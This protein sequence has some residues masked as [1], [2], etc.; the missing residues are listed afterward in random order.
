VPQFILD[1]AIAKGQTCNIII[2][3]PRKIAAITVARRVASERQCNLGQL[4]GYQVGLD[5]MLQEDYKG[6]R[7]IFCTTGVIL[8]KMIQEKSMANYSHIILDEIHEREIDMDL[9]ITVVREFLLHNSGAT[10]LLLMSATLDPKMFIDYFTFDFDVITIKPAVIKLKA[11]RHFKIEKLYLDDLQQQQ[12]FGFN[13]DVVNYGKPGISENLYQLAKEIIVE[14]LKISR[15]SILVFLPGISQIELLHKVLKEEITSCL[16]CVLHSSLSTNDQQA[17]FMPTSKPKI[18]LATNIA[19]SSVT[20]NNISCVIDF[21]LTKII[22]ANKGSTMSSLQLDWAAKDSL[23]QRSGR[24]GRTCD[25]VVYRLIRRSFYSDR[26]QKFSTPEMQR[27]PLETVVLRIK[28]LDIES[29]VTLL[30]KSLSPPQPSAIAKSVLVLKEIGGLERVTD[31]GSFIHSDGKL[32]YVGRIMSALPLDVRVTKLVILGYVYSVLDEAIIIAAGLTIKSI[33]RN[34]FCDK[35]DDYTHKLAWADSS[36]CDFIAILNAYKLWKF[37]SEQG[38]LSDGKTERIWCNQHNLELKNL[39]EMRQ[40]IREI[41]ERL[42]DLKIESLYGELAV[43]WEEKEK[44]L[45]LKICLVGAFIPNFFIA[46]ESN[47]LQEQEIHKELCGKSPYNTVIFRKMD[48]KYIGEV[49]EE[50]IKQKL[51][52][53]GICRNRDN[54][55]IHFEKGSS[56]FMVEFVSGEAMIEGDFGERFDASLSSLVPGKTAPEVYK[57]VKLRKLGFRFKLDVMSSHETEA[58]AVKYGLVVDNNGFLERKKNVMKHPELCVLPLTCAQNLEGRVSHIDHC[59]KFYIQ[60]AT[61]TNHEIL[62][63]IQ[64]MLMQQVAQPFQNINELSQ[65]KLVAVLHSDSLKRGKV[66]SKK[67]SRDVECFLFDFGSTVKVSIDQIFAVSESCFEISERCF[68][69]KLSEIE[70]SFLKCPH[71][72]WT[73]QAVE[74]FRS[75]ALNRDAKVEVY[76]VVGTTASVKLWIED[77][78][79]NEELIEAEFAQE[80]DENFPSKHNHQMRMKIQALSRMWYGP[81]KEWYGHP[82]RMI[83]THVPPPPKSKCNTKL[84]LSGPHSPMETSLIHVLLNSRPFDITVD[85]FSVNSVVLFDN[86]ANIHGRLLVAANVTT[87][88]GRISLHETTMLPEIP[89]LPMLL[90]MIFAPD[91][92]FRRNEERTKYECMQFGL[93]AYTDDSSSLFPEHDCVLPVNFHIDQKDF[94]DV[95]Y[96]RFLM[97]HLLT[98]EPNDQISSLKDEEKS[99]LLRRVKSQIIK[100]LSKNREP[101]VLSY[102]SHDFKNWKTE[103]QS[104]A[105]RWQ[106]VFVG[107]GIYHHIAHPPLVKESLNIQQ[108]VGE[109][110]TIKSEMRT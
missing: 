54:I 62:E 106:D 92:I 1:D 16:I 41:K 42:T 67:S 29:P 68:E 105:R 58:Y 2:S 91:V 31:E 75:F 19:E 30:S 107:G 52:D 60:P 73:S 40:L 80:C 65:D 43:A 15:N 49:Y 83:V 61:P 27:C 59:G 81:E 71:G 39:H 89:G 90:A 48:N 18:I 26:L 63:K 103:D 3:Q 25:G 108:L 100:I 55:R 9:L 28:L 17:V 14:R 7:L 57:A 97:S 98:T 72:K 66:V 44:P 102:A 5:K 110:D 77:L 4:V 74:V 11:D 95:N 70:P 24:T 13:D 8:Q 88:K 53:M 22:V 85:P 87:N 56:K 38:N 84:M 47:E 35:L 6:N 94:W 32:T 23:E 76:S 34:S 79:V 12:Q 101:L 33:F 78:C 20:I 50:T 51:V 21:C 86:P 46:G 45:I 104:D 82:N 69:A 10:K 36:G 96:L 109:I 99:D 64:E 93:G 37:M